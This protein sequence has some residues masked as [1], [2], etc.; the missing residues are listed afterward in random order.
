MW[1]LS[2]VVQLLVAG[3]VLGQGIHFF[4]EDITFRLHHSSL[5][6]DGYYWFCNTSGS[7][8]QIMIYYP[9]DSEVGK[10]D[11]MSVSVLA[12]GRMQRIFNCSNDGFGF[13]LRVPAG[14]TVVYRI[15]YV[16][17]LSGDSALYILRSTRLWNEPL[18]L[19]EYRLITDGSEYLAGFSYEPDTLYQI[20]GKK[21]YYW[22]RTDFMP[23]KDMVFEFRR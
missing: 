7:E 4:R 9:L 1:K 2:V 13:P 6:V 15:A 18:R 11:S 10:V 8:T 19:A 21:I 17:R 3:S 23:E 16:Q 22:K 20:E 12:G 14:D 5:A